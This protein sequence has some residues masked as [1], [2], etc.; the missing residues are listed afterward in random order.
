MRVFFCSSPCSEYQS[1]LFPAQDT[2]HFEHGDKAHHPGCGQTAAV[3]QLLGC[4]HTVP[5]ERD[6]V[7][8]VLIQA[9][10]QRFFRRCGRLGL[11]FRL[12]GGGA[13]LFGLRF[14][15]A[16]VLHALLA[17]GFG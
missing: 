6:D 14:A 7:R 13:A 15:A 11:C 4:A 1:A 9:L 17:A 3:D 10:R 8:F 16:D 12:F 5:H 2:I